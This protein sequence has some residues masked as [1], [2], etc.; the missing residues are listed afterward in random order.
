MDVPFTGIWLEL[1]PDK[2]IE[3]VAGRGADP[4][5]ATAE[6]IRHQI[7]Q[8]RGPVTWTTVPADGSVD[9]VVGRVL[10]LIGAG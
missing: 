1:A 7:S 4:S 5:D 2:L 9:D 6:V 3:R 10:A 8:F